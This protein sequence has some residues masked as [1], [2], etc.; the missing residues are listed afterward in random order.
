[1][2]IWSIEEV[3]TLRYLV[4]QGLPLEEIAIALGRSEFA[5]R[6]KAFIHG[7]SLR[8]AHPPAL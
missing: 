6:N 1:M 5:V 3:R 8:R 2:N 4:G 7:I